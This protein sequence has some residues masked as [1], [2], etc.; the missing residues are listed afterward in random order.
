MDDVEEI[1]E[2]MESL[3][4]FAQYVAAWKIEGEVAVVLNQAREIIRLAKEV[5]E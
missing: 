1:T 4:A 2:K 3:T 5:L